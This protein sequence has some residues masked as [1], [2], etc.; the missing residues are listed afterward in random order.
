MGKL[1]QFKV[2]CEKKIPLAMKDFN[3]RE[4]AIWGASDGGSVVQALLQEQ[5]YQRIF[6]V[7]Q[8]AEETKEYCGC[9][10]KTSDELDVSKH[11]VIVATLVLHEKI[12][13][14]LE[15]RNFTDKDYIYLCDN[16]RYIK[17]DIMYRGCLVGRYTYGYK[18]LLQ[19]FPLATK[20]GRFCS[21]NCT[22]RIWNNHSLDTVT[23][24]PFLDHRLFYSRKEKDMRQALLKKYGKHHD[25][26]D[27]ENSEIRD[28]RPVEIGND[29][30]IG[31]NAIILPG[32][33]IGDGAVI[34]AGAVVTKDVEPYAIV[35]GVPAKIIKY[36]FGEEERKKFLQIKWWDWEI[37]EIER[38]I[39]LFYDPEKFLATYGET[40]T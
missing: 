38:N 20:I 5:G 12:E 1:D 3:S 28:N 11:Y 37:D 18:K 14:F 17:E 35:G 10:V 21:I 7:D 23:T 40:E 6:F 8:K 13:E 30:W 34:A 36:R 32:V 29:V 39:E 22:A 2:I 15:D 16:E 24:H 27:F 25:N 31:A 19:E 33:K 9:P 26:A 4:I